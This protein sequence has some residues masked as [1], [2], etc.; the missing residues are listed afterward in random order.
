MIYNNVVPVAVTVG[1]VFYADNIWIYTVCMGR[2]ETYLVDFDNLLDQEGNI[3]WSSGSYRY[4][5]LHFYHPLRLFV[6]LNFGVYFLL[7]PVIYGAIY[8]FRRNHD[9]TVPGTGRNIDMLF[10][11]FIT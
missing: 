11:I 8:R 4:I 7:V 9:R 10:S 1:S 5:N 3:L 6:A 2:Q